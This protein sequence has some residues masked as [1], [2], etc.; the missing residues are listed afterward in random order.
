MP[1]PPSYIGTARGRI[2]HLCLPPRPPMRSSRQKML[3]SHCLVPVG[4]MRGSRQRCHAHLSAVRT[5]GSTSQKMRWWHICLAA[6]WLLAK[7]CH[8]PCS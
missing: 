7:P 2:C 5:P 3:H 1:A 4:A 6:T 8:P